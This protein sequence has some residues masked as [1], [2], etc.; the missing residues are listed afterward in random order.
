MAMLVAFDR[1]LLGPID[2]NVWKEHPVS[3]EDIEHT[4]PE[5]D[6]PSFA[7]NLASETTKLIRIETNAQFSRMV[8]AAL[9][10]FDRLDGIVNHAVIFLDGM[11]CSLT[12]EDYRNHSVCL[13]KQHIVSARYSRRASSR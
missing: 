11:I 12:A 10:P 2:G 6:L 13:I 9:G 8:Q 1:R 7:G 3:A 5:S 4:K